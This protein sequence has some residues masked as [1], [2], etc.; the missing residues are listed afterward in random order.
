[1]P[2]HAG[3]PQEF[4]KHAIPDYLVGTLTSYPLDY[5]I[6]KKPQ[7]NNSQ[8]NKSDLVLINQNYNYFFC[9]IGKSV[10]FGCVTEFS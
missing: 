8:H 3:V 9:Q 5:Q 1:M 4:L 7:N 6:K 10:L 2:W